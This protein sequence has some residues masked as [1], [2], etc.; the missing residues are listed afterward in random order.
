MRLAASRSFVGAANILAPSLRANQFV[1]MD[2]NITLASRARGTAFIELFDDRP[3]TRDNFLAYVNSGKY[4]GS[5]MHRQAFNGATPFV[6]QGGGFYLQYQ[7]EPAPI[8]ISLNPNATVDL[9][10]NAATPNPTVDNEFGNTPF[11]S[12]VK[13]T[14]A[15]AKLGGDPN[16]ATSQ[17]FFNLGNNAGTSPN[18]LDFQN[19]GFTVFARAVGDGMNLIDAYNGL[20]RLPLDQDADDNGVRDAGPFSSVPALVNSSTFLPLLLNSAKVVNYLGN[21]LTTDVPEAGITFSSQDAFIDTGTV[22]TGTGGLLIGAGRRLGIREGYS[23]N[24]ALAN[25]GTLAPGLQLGAVGV[26]NYF[27]FADG[28]LEIQIR[29]TTVDTDYDRLVVTDS[30]FLAGKLT[31]SFVSGFT[32]SQQHVYR[33]YGG[34]DY[35]CFL[36]VRIT[37]VDRG[38]GVEC[39]SYVDGLYVGRCS[40]GLQYERRGGH[41]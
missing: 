30:A 37:A 33:P 20:S 40:G 10:G 13:G 16:S 25:Q 2:Y 7:T 11:R 15:M 18:G 3:L 27:Q 1:Q 41:R 23:L 36:D 26:P 9:D 32:P 28:N 4:N 35:R 8:N 34:F 12:N 19:G 17:F 14:L 29:N 31:V 5:L 6:L 39:Q 38:P 24:R 22:F 21:G